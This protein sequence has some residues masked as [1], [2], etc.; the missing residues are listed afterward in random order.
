MDV[1]PVCECLTA[2]SVARSVSPGTAGMLSKV[3]CSLHPQWQPLNRMQQKVNGK[4]GF[5][6]SHV[7]SGQVMGDAN[8]EPQREDFTDALDDD[9]DEEQLPERGLL[10]GAI[11]YIAWCQMQPTGRRACEAQVRG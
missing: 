4:V 6:C 11:A 2:Y 8:V 9:K 1:R 7:P 5:D 10:G 3:V